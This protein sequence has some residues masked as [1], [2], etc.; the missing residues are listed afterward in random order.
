MVLDLVNVG[1]F[2]EKKN[3]R[4]VFFLFESK[5]KNKIYF[6]CAIKGDKSSSF[7]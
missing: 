3:V 6:A 5:I 4:M 1:L 7:S 2:Q